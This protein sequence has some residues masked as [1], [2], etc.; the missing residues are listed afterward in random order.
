MN[1][2]VKEFLN[3]TDGYFSS[4]RTVKAEV[5]KAEEQMRNVQEKIKR[6]GRTP[7]L[8]TEEMVAQQGLYDAKTKLRRFKWE[9]ERLYD[10]AVSIKNRYAKSLDD[11]F[12]V[13][14]E[15]LDTATV[16]LLDSGVLKPNDYIHLFESAKQ[17]KNITMMRLIAKSA[18]EY[19]SQNQ[20]NV[21]I[22]EGRKLRIM[23]NDA[24]QMV[25][26]D[27]LIAFDGA[28]AA[29]HRRISE[30]MLNNTDTWDTMIKPALESLDD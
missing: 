4:Y 20:R 28:I 19:E 21:G 2:Y 6:S 27:R 3:L 30:P 9:S 12:I 1:Q 26:G 7:A 16:K 5:D 11:K 17:N 18:R 23:E 24:R 25:G 8:R 14:P 10:K 29:F 13:D 22:D 15:M